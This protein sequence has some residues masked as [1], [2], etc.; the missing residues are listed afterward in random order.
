MTRT[1]IVTAPD[2]G[3]SISFTRDFDAQVAL[4]VRA[5]L[6]AELIG[7]WIGPVGTSVRVDEWDARTGGSYRYAVVASHDEW[8]F[9]GCFHEVSADAGRLVQTWEFAGDPGHPTFEV[10]QFDALDDGAGCRMT[11]TSL[12]LS[13]D[14]RD[15]MLGGMDEGRDIDFERL[16]ALLPTLR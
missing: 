2:G 12:F 9:H 13:V 6:E 14:D 11:S 5:H 3:Q 4:V 1:R 7:Q 16:D 15:A 8:L 10:M